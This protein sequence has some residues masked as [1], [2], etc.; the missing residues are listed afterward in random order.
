MRVNSL[1]GKAAQFLNEAMLPVSVYAQRHEIVHYVV[2]VSHWVEDLIDQ[3]LL[4]GGRD[5]GEAEVI[6]CFVGR[7]REGT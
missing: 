6:V 4:L 2:F 1:R 5:G 3:G 7:V